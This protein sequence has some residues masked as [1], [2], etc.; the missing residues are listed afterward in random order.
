MLYQDTT[1]G[2]MIEDT[3][4]MKL[5]LKTMAN[6]IFRNILAEAPYIEK[7]FFIPNHYNETVELLVDLQIP[8]DIHYQNI[9]LLIKFMPRGVQKID[10][11]PLMKLLQQMFLRQYSPIRN[12]L[13]LEGIL[14][15]IRECMISIFQRDDSRLI[16]QTID[17]NFATALMK[18]VYKD[19]LFFGYAM[20]ILCLLSSHNKVLDL[21]RRLKFHRT[22]LDLLMTKLNISDNSLLA[23]FT[24]IL[25][26]LE[27]NFGVDDLYTLQNFVE[28][29]HLQIDDRNTKL[30]VIQDCW[31]LM[32]HAKQS[33]EIGKIIEVEKA[34]AHLKVIEPIREDG[35]NR[36]HVESTKDP[37]GA[38]GE[39]SVSTQP[40]VVRKLPPD[41]NAIDKSI[42]KLR[43]ESLQFSDRDEEGGPASFLPPKQ[44]YINL[45]PLPQEKQIETTKIIEVELEDEDVALRD[46]TD[47]ESAMIYLRGLYVGCIVDDVV[48]ERMKKAGIEEDGRLVETEEE[49]KRREERAQEEPNYPDNAV[50]HFIYQKK[51]DHTVPADAYTK[52]STP[53]GYDSAFINLDM[54]TRNEED[55]NRS[56]RNIHSP[57]YDQ[58]GQGSQHGG[59][60]RVNNHHDYSYHESSHHEK[61]N[62][63]NVY[64]SSTLT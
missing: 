60:S 12:P 9:Q 41:S 52:A 19:S 42:E 32:A 20:D 16:S 33:R 64:I 30:P 38:I 27:H 37:R 11:R 50:I 5:E 44:V 54:A 7:Q 31:L 14:W 1:M 51:P 35:S 58:R 21:F 53:A 56:R 23:A 2:D 18:L 15:V 6:I 49:T 46:L 43:Q 61:S 28:A 29:F 4:G 45:L 26:T 57:V 8:S 47:E 34:H 36:L 40:S 62:K 55:E 22:L 17:L 13:T 59:R 3:E 48:G 10:V 39:S 25:Y 63:V 24:I